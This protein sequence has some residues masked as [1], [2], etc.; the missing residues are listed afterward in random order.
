MAPPVEVTR[1]EMDG[2]TVPKENWY[3]KT[4][5]RLAELRGSADALRSAAEMKFG[6]KNREWEASARDRPPPVTTNFG[7]EDARV[8]LG[9]AQDS[10]ELLAQE[11][12]RTL[13]AFHRPEVAIPARP[14]AAP[15]GPAKPAEPVLKK[16]AG[17]PADADSGPVALFDHLKSWFSTI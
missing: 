12:A 7:A 11:V 4:Y 2:W 13:K 6:R 14:A 10:S 16:P 3:G 1:E 9:H 17:P 8:L 15:A 5:G